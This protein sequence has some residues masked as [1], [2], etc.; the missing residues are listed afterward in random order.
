MYLR[1]CNG[2]E[3]TDTRKSKRILKLK[4]IPMLAFKLSII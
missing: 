4:F 2:N 1:L 3:K